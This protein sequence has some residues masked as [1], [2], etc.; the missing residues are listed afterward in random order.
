MKKK[1]LFYARLI[2]GRCFSLYL[3]EEEERT[4]YLIGGGRVIG[5]FGENLWEEM[6][7]EIYK[8]WKDNPALKN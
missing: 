6:G 1:A 3:V 7:E 2:G 8:L 5:Y 4:L